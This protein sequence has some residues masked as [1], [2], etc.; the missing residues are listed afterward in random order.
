MTLSLHATIKADQY[1]IFEVKMTGSEKPGVYWTVFAP[2]DQKVLIDSWMTSF[3]AREEPKVVITFDL[4]NLPPFTQK[5]LAALVDIP[6]GTTASYGDIAAILGNPK[7]ARPV[8]T[9]CGRNPVPLLIPCHRVI[10][11]SRKI[12]GF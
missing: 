7:G 10:A 1:G 4:M 9:A 5:V 12:G 3:A 11:A 2:A 8:G 6:F